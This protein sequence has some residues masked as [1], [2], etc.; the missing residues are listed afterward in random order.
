MSPT[1]LAGHDFEVNLRNLNLARNDFE[2]KKPDTPKRF[3]RLYR[4]RQKFVFQ[5]QQLSKDSIAFDTVDSR[6]QSSSCVSS[7]FSESQ[8]KQIHNI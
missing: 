7:R 2:A 6:P 3:E 8:K 1:A 5:E 4:E